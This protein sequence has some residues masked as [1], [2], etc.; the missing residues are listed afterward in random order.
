MRVR[1]LQSLFLSCFLYTPY[2]KRGKKGANKNRA[3][4][5]R[6]ILC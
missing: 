4:Q 6:F 5:H 3:Y 1:T 2:Y